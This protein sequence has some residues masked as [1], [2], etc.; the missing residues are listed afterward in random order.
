MSIILAYV[1]YLFANRIGV[2]PVMAVVSAGLFHKRTERVIKARTRLSEQAVWDTLIFFLTG[3]IFIVIGLQFQTYLHKVNY[4]FPSTLVLLSVT[5]IASIVLIRLLLVSATVYLN[6]I[7]RYFSRPGARAHVVWQ[8]ILISSW[9]GMR[10]LVSL[11]LAIALP[12]VL[13]N[14]SAFPYRNLIIFLT[15]ITI[16]FTLLIQGLTLP[17][18]VKFLRMES[19]DTLFAKE[20]VK[21]YRTLTKKAI[22]H[23]NALESNTHICSNN[24]KKLVNSYYSR[25][26]LQFKV[27]YET[28]C[29][30]H[31]V[32]QEAEVLLSRILSYERNVLHQMRTKKR[33]SEEIY[34]HILKKIDQDEVGFASYK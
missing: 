18:L 9:S 17:L 11:A 28:T 1:A 33:I 8:E 6:H 3:L 16:L 26:L 34:L 24:A 32:G 4:L 2:S 30:T 5:A 12:L 29:D 7:L 31:E 19:T 13:P 25:R 21:I 20:A 15:I 22:K 27:T 14:G 10:G 23:I